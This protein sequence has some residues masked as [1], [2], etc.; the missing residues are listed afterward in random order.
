MNAIFGIGIAV[1]IFIVALLG[2]RAFYPE[3]QYSTYCNDSIYSTPAMPTMSFSDCSQNITVAECNAL[4]GKNTDYISYNKKIDLEM[5]ECNTKYNDA[6]KAYGK[7]FFII[8][9]ILGLIAIIVAYFLLDIL[10]LSAGIAMS[11]IVLIIVAF[12]RGWNDTNDILKF[13]V[14][15][16]IAIVI[17][18]L[19]LK[20][21]KQLS[22]EK[23][24]RKR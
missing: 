22:N 20:V 13:V 10:S 21:N 3:P 15:L 18:F 14:G 5:Q 16:V 12:S 9:S 1:I 17:I 11:G 24:K 7:I 23:T 2:I 8:A 19:T 6:N 4:I